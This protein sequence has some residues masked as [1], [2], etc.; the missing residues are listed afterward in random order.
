MTDHDKLIED[1]NAKCDELYSVKVKLKSL[2]DDYFE[3][4]KALAEVRA[5]LLSV[6]SAEARTVVWDSWYAS[7][8]EFLGIS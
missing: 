3:A 1:Y 5:I 2:A 4:L 7:A 6:P 8:S